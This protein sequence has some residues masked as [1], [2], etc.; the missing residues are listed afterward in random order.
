MAFLPRHGNLGVERNRMM[1]PRGGA[2]LLRLHGG[3]GLTLDADPNQ[4]LS[5]SHPTSHGRMPCR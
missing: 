5:E 3:T 1:V 4:C 2:N